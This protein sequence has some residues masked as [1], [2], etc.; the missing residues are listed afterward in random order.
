MV[1]GVERSVGSGGE[2]KEKKKNG[3]VYVYSE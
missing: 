2:K 3:K 1:R